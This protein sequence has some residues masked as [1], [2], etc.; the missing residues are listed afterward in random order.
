MS[1]NKNYSFLSKALHHLV[2]GSNMIPEMLYDIEMSIFKKKLDKN[3]SKSHIFVCGLPRSGT[4]ILMNTLYDT[5]QFASL[6]YRDMPFVISPNLWS[7]IS[8]RDI[9]SMPAKERLHGD[10]IK[11]NI[12]SP[13]ALEEVF[14]RVKSNKQYIYSNKLKI[15]EADEE[16]INEYRNFVLLILNKYK[17]KFYI[18]KNNNNILRLES[19]IKA[20]PNCLV[21]I[22]FRDPIQQANSLLIQH[23]N[24]TQIQKQDKFVKKYMA[25]L[26]HHEFGIIHRPYEF[27]ENSET[28]FDNNSIEY[29]L[30]QWI[31]AYSY[32]SQKKFTDNKNILYLNYEYW[33]ENSQNVLKKISSKIKLDNSHFINN[34]KL[35]KSIKKVEI[36]E[37][38]IVS[39]SRNIFNNLNAINNES[40]NKNN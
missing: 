28:S 21:I 34:L 38:S 20:F 13:E 14:W 12:D 19:I 27:F 22:P 9:T 5:G 23:K 25:Y 35:K 37:N 10:S 26:V 3:N 32:L 40:F 29:W 31:N 18:S 17:K 33:C 4:T 24:F 36:K 30:M 16:T 39:K 15:H 7:K 1:L 6:T 11:V 8:S 2:L